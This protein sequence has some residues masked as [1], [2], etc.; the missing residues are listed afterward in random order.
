V[1]SLQSLG[2]PTGSSNPLAVMFTVYVTLCCN[3]R[4]IFN[5]NIR[6]ILFFNLLMLCAC[7]IM[8]IVSVLLCLNEH[9]YFDNIPLILQVIEQADALCC[10]IIIF[11]VYVL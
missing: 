11:I 7:A 6:T 4:N 3:K 1:V 5:Q 9:N 2:T 8:I 10:A